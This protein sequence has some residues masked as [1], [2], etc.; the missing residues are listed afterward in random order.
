YLLALI[1][2]IYPDPKIDEKIKEMLTL[3]TQH[4]KAKSLDL[5]DSLIPILSLIDPKTYK[6]EKSK[7]YQ[8]L[9]KKLPLKDLGLRNHE[10]SVIVNYAEDI[11]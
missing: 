6:P 2:E 8:R 11:K 5:S 10:L 3:Y 4:V 9:K 1:R 7:F